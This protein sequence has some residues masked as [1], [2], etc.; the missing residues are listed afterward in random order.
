M[1]NPIAK[2][3]IIDCHIHLRTSG[4]DMSVPLPSRAQMFDGMR[5]AGVAGGIIFSTAPPDK[6]PKR[7]GDPAEARVD[8]VLQ[9]CAAEK[10]LELYP[11]LYINPIEPDAVAQVAMAKSKG[12]KGFKII[13]TQHYPGDERAIPTYQAMAAANMPLLFHSGI[14]FGS[15]P[16]SDF[17]RPA[18]FEPLM[19]VEGLRFAMAH[20]SWP[21]CEEMIAVYGKIRN[22]KNH[23]P[24]AAE[25]WVDTTP[26]T[27]L[28]GRAEFMHRFYQFGTKS[29]SQ[30]IMFG[31]DCMLGT[32][33]NAEAATRMIEHDEQVSSVYGANAQYF[34]ESVLWFLNG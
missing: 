29:I 32:G 27:P 5:E 6:H 26:G 21:W 4:H 12:V 23:N 10:D 31:T 3:K 19:F 17:N 9:V 14:L 15:T 11:F 24:N 22:A 34:N 8:E 20:M 2:T 25:L 1:L 13:C 33:Y 7:K 16:T 18:A 30:R 28:Y